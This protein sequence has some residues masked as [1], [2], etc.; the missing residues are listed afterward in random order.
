MLFYQLLDLGNIDPALPSSD[1]TIQAMTRSESVTRGD[2]YTE[3]VSGTK[4]E[5]VDIRGWVG[6]SYYFFK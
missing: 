4:V 3:P 2:V 1:H 5:V 6:A